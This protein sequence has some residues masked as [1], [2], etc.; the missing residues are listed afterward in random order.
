MGLL[1]GDQMPCDERGFRLRERGIGW[2][3][4]IGT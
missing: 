2:Q 4:S 1:T 3:E